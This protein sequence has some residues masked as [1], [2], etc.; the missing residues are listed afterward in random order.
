MDLG[1]EVIPARDTIPEVPL[2]KELRENKKLKLTGY[3]EEF[4]IL[5]DDD[6]R[7]TMGTKGK[8]FGLAIK[9]EHYWDEANSKLIGA[10]HF[11]KGCEGAAGLVHGGAIATAF[12]SILGW[13]VSRTAG[14]GSFTLNLNVNYRK[15]IPLGAVVKI[16]CAV[17]KKEGRKI[18]LEGKMSN[19]ESG[20][21]HAE[22]TALFY[23]TSAKEVSFES[24]K[25]RIGVSSGITK[26]VIIAA[27]QKRKAKEQRENADKINAKL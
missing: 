3:V 5:L 11:T 19:P 15:F 25:K 6:I 4:P 2:L 7:T 16:E 21:V 27:I 8:T 17:V 20:E 24:L 12:D 23:N 10:V 22:A 18:Y 9:R 26:E 14:F 13:T 1:F